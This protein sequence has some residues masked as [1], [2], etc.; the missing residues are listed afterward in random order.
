MRRKT[1]AC[2]LQKRNKR[3]LTR[4]DLDKAKKRNH[5][6]LSESLLIAI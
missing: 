4:E 3:N 6:R 2:I 5:N 1:T